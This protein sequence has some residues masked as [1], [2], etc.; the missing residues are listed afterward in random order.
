MKVIL[1]G[2]CAAL[3]AGCASRLA[4]P[5]QADSWRAG[6]DLAELERGREQYAARCSSCHNLYLPDEFPAAKWP[7]ILDDMGPRA[8]LSAEQRRLIEC[9][10]T[11]MAYAAR[12]VDPPVPK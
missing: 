2:I 8:G 1:I 11:T 7:R 6:S 4:H 10:L 3:I 12:A 9:Y 5:T